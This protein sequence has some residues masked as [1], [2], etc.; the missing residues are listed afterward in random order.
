[1]GLFFLHLFD[2]QLYFTF[3]QIESSKLARLLD[4]IDAVNNWMVESFLQLNPDKPEILIIAPDSAIP[5]IKQSIGPLSSVVRPSIRN[6]GVTFDKSLS[7]GTH[8]KSLSKSCFFHL[9]NIS[10][11]RAV[12]SQS[13]IEML[14]HAFFYS[15]ID[16][17]NSFFSS[18]NKSVLTITYRALHGQAPSCQHN[19]PTHPIPVSQVYPSKSVCHSTPPSED[20]W[21]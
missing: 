5:L 17:C 11:L 18:L 13:E 2:I 12:V 20:M 7:F 6:L 4:C 9:R 8:I 15:R 1:M 21:G 16:N 3:R 10:K 14:I 19:S